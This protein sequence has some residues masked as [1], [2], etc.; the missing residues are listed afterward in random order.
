MRH[1][2]GDHGA[3]AGADILGRGARDQASALAPTLR[4][5]SRAARDRASIRWRRRRRGDSGRSAI[6]AISGCARRRAPSPNRTAAAVGIGIPA[7]AQLDRIDLHPQRGLVD[8]LFQRERH[9]RSAGPAERRAGRQIADDVEVGELLCLCRIDQPRQCGDGGVD[10]R[11]GVGISGERQRLQLALF[12]RQQRDLDF[13]CRPIAGHRKLFVAVVGDADRRLGG[14]RQLDRGGRLHAEA[15]LRAET[16]ADM[17]G[18]HLH[19]VVIELVAFG[20]QLHQME[21]RL[22][23]DVHGQA[24][25]V[26]TGDGGMRLQAGMRLRAGPEDAFD[27]QRIVGLARALDPAPHF[28]RLE[29]ERRRRPADIALPRRRRAAAFRDVAGL[30]AVGLVEHDRRVRLARFIEPDRRRQPF[31]VDLDG[32]DRRQRGLA[33]FRRDGRDRLRRHS[34]RCGPRRAARSPR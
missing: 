12:G 16:A 5:S 7:F 9:R 10:R 3:A 30:L 21:H 27:Q 32:G 26:E 2:I 22:R 20:D 4:P 1:R 25:A 8:R 31:A 34:G 6:P 13:G 23:R 11:T 28:L 15:G 17:V 19:L 24:V 33:I 18:D 14:A 29:R